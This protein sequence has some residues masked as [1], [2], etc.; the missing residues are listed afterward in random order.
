MYKNKVIQTGDEEASTDFNTKISIETNTQEVEEGMLAIEGYETDKDVIF[1]API[2]GALESNIT[3]TINQGTLTIRGHRENLIRK[4]SLT[5]YLCQECF[6]GTFS[7][8]IKLPKEI[9]SK[10]P[11]ASLKNGILKI[12]FHKS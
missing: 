12:R 8:S 5:N 4:Q 9:K 1:L 10:K 6:W 11:H 3:L 2:A 7:R